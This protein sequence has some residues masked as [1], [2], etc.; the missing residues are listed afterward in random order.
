MEG[1]GPGVIRK[2]QARRTGKGV[3]QG[4]LCPA[5]VGD[6]KRF[7]NTGG[8]APPSARKIA[9]C[10]QQ[11]GEGRTNRETSSLLL[12]ESGARNLVAWSW[13]G[14]GAGRWRDV[15][16][17]CSGAGRRVQVKGDTPALRLGS[18][19]LAA[20]LGMLGSAGPWDRQWAGAQFGALWV[21]DTTRHPWRCRPGRRRVQ[22]YRSPGMEGA[23]QERVH[24]GGKAC[25]GPW[26]PAVTAC[27]PGSFGGACRVAG[28]QRCAKETQSGTA[29][30]GGC[31]EVRR[32]LGGP[33]CPRLGLAL[34]APSCK[35]QTFHSEV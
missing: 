20:P 3:Q 19:R 27:G 32:Y 10:A 33:R 12:A 8:L 29:R 15:W 25:I 11:S 4:I 24:P 14:R 35:T 31:W 22:G 30:G 34:R 16:D 23:T 7:S 17:L 6:G 28:A 26:T 2:G 13:K 1:G 5:G 9:G 21:P 18:W